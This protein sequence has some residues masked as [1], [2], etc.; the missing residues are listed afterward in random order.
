MYGLF[1]HCSIFPTWFLS[2]KGRWMPATGL[3]PQN[4]SNMSA[5]TQQVCMTSDLQFL[6]SPLQGALSLRQDRQQRGQVQPEDAVWGETQRLIAAAAAAQD[7]GL[8]TKHTTRWP[9]TSC[10]ICRARALWEITELEV[11]AEV[12]D[13]WSKLCMNKLWELEEVKACFLSFKGEA[14][15][16]ISW[17]EGTERT[18]VSWHVLLLLIV[19]T[20]LSLIETMTKQWK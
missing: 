6:L 1:F 15:W 20:S 13:S 8:N 18:N 2:S 3:C 14:L 10:S 11:S 17:R 9:L 7:S 4:T 19:Q 5:H 12:W 16:R